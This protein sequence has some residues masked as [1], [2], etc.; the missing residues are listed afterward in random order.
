MK[1]EISRLTLITEY[2]L[3]PESALFNQETGARQKHHKVNR[4]VLK[5]RRFNSFRLP[6]PSHYYA[7]YFP[8]LKI[9]TEC[10]SVHCCFHDD[11]HPSLR[12]NLRNGAFRCFGCGAKGGDVLAFHQQR[13]Q[14]TF[15]EAVSF[16]GAWDE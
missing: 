9:H 14:L 7:Q 13:F 5:D 15:I 6:K 2:E 16:L 8:N 4:P 11:A 1:T 3:A 10:V 12:L